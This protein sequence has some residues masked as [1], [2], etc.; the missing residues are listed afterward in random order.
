MF[1][2]QQDTLNKFQIEKKTKV[3][4]ICKLNYNFP[5]IEKDVKINDN[6]NILQKCGVMSYSELKT[7]R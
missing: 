4:K 3:L 7:K 5:S 1:N 2:N 6:C